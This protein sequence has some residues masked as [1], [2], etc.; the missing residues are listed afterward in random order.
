MKRAAHKVTDHAVVRY[1]ERVRGID[2]DAIRAEIG[3]VVDRAVTRA[4]DCGLEANAR[5][6]NS[7]GFTFK[8]Q[9]GYVITILSK[10]CPNYRLGRVKAPVCENDI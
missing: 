2:I 1:L 5:G 3:L 6:V 7:G 10:N 8:I 4:S 9:D